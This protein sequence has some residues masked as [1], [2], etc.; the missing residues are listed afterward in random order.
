MQ[1]KS[2]VIIHTKKEEEALLFCRLLERILRRALLIISHAV[3][4]NR[5]CKLAIAI[6]CISLA[7]SM[8]VCPLA[9]FQEWILALESALIASLLLPAYCRHFYGPVGKCI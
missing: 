3:K 8:N 6:V 2:N 9:N 1:P 4:R 5:D 7:P